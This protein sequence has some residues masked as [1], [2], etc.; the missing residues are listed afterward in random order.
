MNPYCII[1]NYVTGEKYQLLFDEKDMEV[2]ENHWNKSDILL[3]ELA[4]LNASYANK[5]TWAELTLKDWKFFIDVNLKKFT[6]KQNQEVLNSLN[7]LLC[8]FCKCLSNVCNGDV[9]S[10]KIQHLNNGTVNFCYCITSYTDY[11]I[12]PKQEQLTLTVV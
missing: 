5:Q 3:T 1:E 4:S 2:V 9:E 12:E 10:L 7:F 11:I 6:K 8:G